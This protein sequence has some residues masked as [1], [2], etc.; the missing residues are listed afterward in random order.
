MLPPQKR[1]IMKSKN[2]LKIQSRRWASGV[3]LFITLLTPDKGKTDD[4]EKQ[5]GFTDATLKVILE[6]T[7][8]VRLGVD[9]KTDKI[10]IVYLE[11]GRD[12]IELSSPDMAKWLVEAKKYEHK[13]VFV[14]G[15]VVTWS[16]PPFLPR[17]EFANLR[18]FDETLLLIERTVIVKEIRIVE[19]KK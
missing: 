12:W 8:T 7:G 16:Y 19:T 5:K 10:A 4:K 14:K 1:I 6:C 2:T 9:P 18:L 3:I 15:E 13:T 17:P 11:Q